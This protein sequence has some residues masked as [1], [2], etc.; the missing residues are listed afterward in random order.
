MATLRELYDRDFTQV[1]NTGKVLQLRTAEG[2]QG[3]H[4]RVHLDF[5]AN[6]KFVSCYLPQ[7]SN[8]PILNAL[9]NQ[10]NELVAMDAAAE[11]HSVAPGERP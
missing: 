2:L 5:D 6:A 9:L 7:L 11:V 3:F 8:E 1:L 10:L 4:A